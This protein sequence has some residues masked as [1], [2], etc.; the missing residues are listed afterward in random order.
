MEIWQTFRIKTYVEEIGFLRRSARCTGLEKIK[1][2]AIRENMNI[3]NSVLDDYIRYK[4]LNWFGH[5]Q[6]MD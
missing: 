2:N 6:R 3:K 1:N 5:V 4:Q